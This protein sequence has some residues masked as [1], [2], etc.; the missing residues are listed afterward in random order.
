MVDY[1]YFFKDK[2]TD[3]RD[4]A[5]LNSYDLFISSFINSERVK[6]VF[7]LVPSTERHWII[8]A[9]YNID[10]SLFRV[11]A[12]RVFKSNLGDDE[13]ES[14]NKYLDSFDVTTYKSICIDTTGFLIPHLLFL[15]RRLHLLGVKKIDFLYTEP[16]TYI[17][18]EQTVFTT[19]FH[20]VR[21][22]QGYEG[23]HNPD[24]S[25][26]VLLIASG[27]DDSRITDVANNK[28]KARKIQLFG[29][30]SLQ[31]DMYQENI[32]KAYKAEAAVGGESFNDPASNLYAPANDPFVA[33][34][35]ISR[36][37]EKEMSL[38]TFTNMYLCPIST[39]PHALGLAFYYI[40]ECLSK[41]VSIIFPFCSTH[42]SNTTE[43][44]GKVLIFTFEFS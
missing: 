13:S 4:V 10:D 43:G 24:I 28:A 19:D 16:N 3:Y 37:F 23:N 12:D 30:P 44:I 5:S 2:F 35:V 27:Y 11:S 36:F 32:I 18:K 1:S 40:N 15:L 34:E 9:E 14:I 25:N 17:N 26:D 8:F 33:A 42:I 29:F 22:I 41:P 6:S 7:S 21:Q 20:Y 39:K 38:K 31:P